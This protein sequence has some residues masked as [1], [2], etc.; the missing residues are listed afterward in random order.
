[1][2]RLSEPSRTALEKKVQGTRAARL[3]SGYGRPS[4]ETPARLPKKSE[5]TTHEPDWLQHRPGGPERGLAVAHGHVPG[6]DLEGKIAV[7]PELARRQHAA[8]AAGRP[9]PDRHQVRWGSAWLS[10]SARSKSG[11]WPNEA[12]NLLRRTE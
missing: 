3:N 4:E 2:T 7:A 6:G 10:T 1:M 9:E 12:T 8:E 5:K 11:S